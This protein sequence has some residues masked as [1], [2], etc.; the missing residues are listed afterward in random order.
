MSEFLDKKKGAALALL[1]AAVY[2]VSYVSRI[3]MSAVL[4]EIIQS[5]FA[6]RSVA[7]L[8]LTACS[9]TYGVGQIISGYLGDRFKPQYI[10]FTGFMVTSLMNILVS[11]MPNGTLLVPI[12]AVNGFAQAMMWPP[13]ITIL[14][15][16][17][18]PDQYQKACVHVSW[19][20]S[21]GTIAV[22]LLAPLLIKYAS[23]KAVFIVSGIM[24]LL[25]G[26]FWV[27]IFGKNFS[28][29]RKSPEVTKTETPSQDRFTASTAVLL[30]FI[31]FAIV[32]Q[33]ALRDGVTN[34]MPSYVSEIFSLGSSA[35]ILTGVILPVFSI[36]SFQAAQFIY[37]KII[38]NELTCACSFFLI[39]C[40]SAVLLN[41]TGSKS[42]LISLLMF[43]LLVGSMHGVNLILICMVPP[44][45]K[46]FGRVSLVSGVI[47]S[48]TY[49]GSAISTYGI[50]VFTDAFGWSATSLFWAFIAIAGA[51]TCIAFSKKWDRFTAK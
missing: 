29:E 41:I 32:L 31:M 22:Y 48:C 51:L 5:G 6:K 11:L 16:N 25:M 33:G 35:S 45:F 21:F 38:K 14:A 50:A 44:H 7:A 20:S 30:I 3:N 47:N 1:C 15:Q 46:R 18:E 43:A 39:G 28:G 37:E 26:I 19:G 13:L 27:I 34:W 40:I 17:L 10:I 24:A 9:I 42:V 8:T 36:I 49:V 23:F 4:V 2:F 12:W